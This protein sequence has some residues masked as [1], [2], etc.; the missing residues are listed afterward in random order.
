MADHVT[1]ANPLCRYLDK[2]ASDFARADML[3]I[4]TE[5]GIERF[6]FHY[7]GID[8]Q[9]KELRLPFSNLRQAETILASG[10]R[11]DGS[12]LFK[13]LIDPSQS[14]LYVVPSY[15]TAFIN[16]FDERSLD[17][18][19]RF[20]G[21]D[22]A[23]A[24]FTP[25][26]LLVATHTRFQQR[27]GLELYAMGELEFFLIG[28]ANGEYYVPQRQTGYQ[29]S[30]PFFTGGDVVN[31]M[32]RCIVQIT[33]AVKYAHAEVGF[34][35]AIR[36]DRPFLVGK[37]AEQHEIEFLT[38]PIAD[39]GDDVALARWIIRNVA[40]R[41]GMLATFTPKL[42]EGIAGNGLH[43]HMELLRS[44]RNVMLRPDGALS[45]EALKLIGG[46]VHYAATL[47]AFG[48]TV[49]SAFLRLV[50]NQEAPTRIC[51]S[52]A[53]RS[54]LIRVP[55]GWNKTPN[56]AAVVNPSEKAPF[57]DERGR[58]TVE[59]R[60]PD[61]SALFNLLLTGLT[62][63]AEFGLT[64][65]GMLELAKRT[66]VEGN[67]FE[68]AEHMAEF[69]AL[70]GSCV[71]AAHLLRERRALYEGSGIITPALIDYVIN[72]LLA[73]NDETLNRDLSKMPAD[74]RL[75]ATRQVMH[76]DIHRH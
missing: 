15:R 72:L 69:E 63:A 74:E 52:E 16:P 42:E 4:A 23:P 40:A 75:T 56:L 76:R 48:N 11:V 34:I 43:V 20:V 9:L 31:E 33:G 68:N 2:E 1:L 3:R 65:Q 5:R 45:D 7:T 35:D 32:V 18:M 73:E 70:P 60:S 53:N 41:H 59:I 10:E 14:D 36:S 61:G 64:Q 19:C 17:F 49:A 55:L 8:N 38:R 62:T 58:Q 67:V 50:P 12:S 25:D 22:G 24:P 28:E 46:L 44:G 30:S 71:A 29:A 6:T 57:T 51:W 54:A 13:R 39:M 27:T 21:R 37:R 66:R 26:N 47:S